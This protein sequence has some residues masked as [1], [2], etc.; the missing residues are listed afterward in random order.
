MDVALNNQQITIKPKQT[1]PN[2]IDSLDSLITRPI[3]HR[4]S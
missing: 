4:S 2:S 1:S 3:G